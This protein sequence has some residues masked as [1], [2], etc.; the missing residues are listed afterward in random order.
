M[1]LCDPYAI[2]FLANS[3]IRLLQYLMN[4]EAMP[5]ENSVLVLMLRMLAL[6][7]HSWDMIESQVNTL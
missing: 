2:N 7:L 6:G 1:I 5:R 4:N 3:V